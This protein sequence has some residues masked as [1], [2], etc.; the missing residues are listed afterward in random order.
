M[1][2]P[3]LRREGD[4]FVW[5]W[6]E[7]D[8]RIRLSRLR[9][10]DGDVVADVRITTARPVEGG[11]YG[12]FFAGRVN[13]SA[14]RSRRDLA[15]EL[16]ALQAKINW[17]A[18]LEH[19]F[20]ETL[21]LF[22]S[23]DPVV[24]L[25]D[26]PEPET[27]PYLLE[28]LL[29]Q[30]KPTVVFAPGGTGKSYLCLAL[31]LAV[32]EGLPL[33]SGLRVRQ[34]CPVLYLNW[35][36]DAEDQRVRLG[37]LARGWRL[38]K[39]PSFLHRRMHRPLADD[40]GAV[41][42]CVAEEGVGLVI[43]D[44]IAMAAGGEMIEAEPVIRFFQALRELRTSALIISHISKND[45]LQK[46]STPYGSVFVLNGA[47]SAWE[48][49]RESESENE[50]VLALYHRKVN[51]G[52]LHGSPIGLRIL[53][54]PADRAVFLYAADIAEHPDLSESANLGWR[55][56]AAL[57]AARHPLSTVQLA[58]RLGVGEDHVRVTL[59]RLRKA[60]RVVRLSEN[61]EGG[62]GKAGLWALAAETEDEPF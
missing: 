34:K 3:R 51:H 18:L 46:Q 54:D 47:R 21:D 38:E 57:R 17:R 6:D 15:R 58:E 61:L 23:G 44:S 27:P 2:Q 32:Q 26:L 13:L 19:A 29:Q 22:E 50:I 56:M 55:I 31:G 10:D 45:L 4:V 41:R 8:V 25:A 60:G 5:T 16:A 20:V 40:L 39:I 14:P 62:R 42:Q 49:R 52:P 53:F 9:E 36:D 35:E 24:N 11:R 43:I 33:P 28:P 7:E 59:S 30:G 48:L 37:W 1:G 12:H